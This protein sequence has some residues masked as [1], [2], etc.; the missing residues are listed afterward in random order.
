MLVK[1]EEYILLVGERVSQ[2][3][4]IRRIDFGDGQ[5]LFC[6]FESWEHSKIA[7]SFLFEDR[8]CHATSLYP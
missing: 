7:F 4:S 5:V 3:F 6:V 2:I 1:R 8:H